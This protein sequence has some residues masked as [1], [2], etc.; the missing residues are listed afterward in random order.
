MRI[1]PALADGPVGL[2]LTAALG[3]LIAVSLWPAA[4]PQPAP[5]GEP[6]SAWH[7]VPGERPGRTGRDD[8][9][10]APS[11][12]HATVVTPTDYRADRGYGL[13]IAF[14]PAGFRPEASERYYG[15]TPNATA[16]GWIVAYP[17]ALPLSEV[18]LERQ[19][20]LVD[21]LAQHWCVDPSRV[22]AVGHSDG[23]SVA[24]GNWL[25][26]TGQVV[27]RQVVASAAGLQAEDLA[28][29]RCPAPAGLTVVHDPDDERFPNYG[30]QVAGWFA[31]C[32]H[33]PAPALPPVPGD[34]TE[35]HACRGGAVLRHCR[36]GDGHGRFPAW[37]RDRL[38]GW[39]AD[40]PGVALQTAAYPVSSSP[41]SH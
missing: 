5:A 28:Y 36:S 27:A 41:R 30:A 17:Q 11:G 6:P 19:Q 13:L 35:T 20:Q 14:P 25:R 9:W 38:G 4:L 10:R 16:A 8:G 23:G 40:R 18:A 31:A 26:P 1:D 3:V 33:C 29:E 7:C 15:L 22:A 21:A 32:W 12:L 24:L 2:C 39:L 34:C 37:I